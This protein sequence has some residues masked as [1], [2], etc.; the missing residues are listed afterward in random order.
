[1]DPLTPA[2]RRELRAQA[3]HLRPVVAI[4]HH[5]LTPAVVREIDVALKAHELI[6]LRVLGDDRDERSK[7]LERVCAELGCAPVQQLG[8][9]L[10][11]WRERSEGEAPAKTRAARRRKTEPAAPSAIARKKKPEPAAA[12]ET[13]RPARPRSGASG[14]RAPAGVARAALRRRRRG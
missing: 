5:G 1:M 12:S 8:K 14:P 11:V 13:T 6:K 9:L 4:G 2:R 10:I 3:H 7:L